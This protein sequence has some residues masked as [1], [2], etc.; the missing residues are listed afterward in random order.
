MDVGLMVTDLRKSFPAPSGHK[1]DVL[2]GISFSVQPGQSVA[3]VGASG[4]GKS[5][6]LNLLGG[7]EAPDHG[8][9]ALGKFAIDC[10]RSSE[11]ATFR[12]N[13]IGFVFQFHYLLGDL[14]ALENVALPLWIGRKSRPAALEQALASLADMGL[15]D[16]GDHPVSHL[17]G[18][19][20]QRVATCRAL[21]KQPA[22]VLADEPT[23]N[24]DAAA[25][26]ELGEH[27][28]SYAQRHRSIV[29]IATHNEKLAQLC[30]QTLRIDEGRLK[31]VS[32]PN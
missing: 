29:V 8:S 20:Q 21:I 24:L 2:R 3:I 30:N 19:E 14:S 15:K 23:G 5:T 1:L 32:D 6:L 13:H 4:A 22:L 28:I 7:L 26:Q 18:G 11:L 9:I 27:L 10:A 17:S 31:V 25:A 12:R 16:R